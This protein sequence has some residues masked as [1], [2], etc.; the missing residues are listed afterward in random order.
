MTAQESNS[1][2]A[3]MQEH[4]TEGNGSTFQKT[5]A[6][7]FL[8]NVAKEV[9]LSTNPKPERTRLPLL[10]ETPFYQGRYS[11]VLI[12]DRRAT[13][14]LMVMP[15]HDPESGQDRVSLMR[16]ALD[17]RTQYKRNKLPL[18]ISL[19]AL[20]LSPVSYKDKVLRVIH[21]EAVVGDIDPRLFPQES[22]VLVSDLSYAQT[23]T[24]SSPR[25]TILGVAKHVEDASRLLGAHSLLE[26]AMNQEVM[27]R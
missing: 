22:N 11:D 15:Y 1:L 9:I 3:Y 16:V 2:P 5:E 25:T 19:G 26:G 7:K 23:P 17:T 21:K 20:A 24:C 10:G 27:A 18:P 12:I 6:A 13:D 8:F 14:H 4:F